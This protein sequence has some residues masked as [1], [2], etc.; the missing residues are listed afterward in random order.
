VLGQR[1]VG[2]VPQ[3]FVAGAVRRAEFAQQ[4]TVVERD[5]RPP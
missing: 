1:V 3:G 2:A 5:G 4:F